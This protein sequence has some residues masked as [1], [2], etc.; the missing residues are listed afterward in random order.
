MRETMFPH[1][2]LLMRADAHL[3][4]R[5]GATEQNKPGHLILNEIR[6]RMIVLDRAF[7]QLSR[8]RQTASL[9]ANRRQ[10]DSM[11]RRP[12]PDAL[13]FTAIERTDSLRGVQCNPMDPS[14]GHL[15]FDALWVVEAAILAV[16]RL[17]RF[18]A[19]EMS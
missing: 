7:E 14:F 12:V 8:A 4:L 10:D 15:S 2:P 19:A 11:R 9:M 13:V 1:R 3:A 6:V 18:A 16:R 5:H 17:A